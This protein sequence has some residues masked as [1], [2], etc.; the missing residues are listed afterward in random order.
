MY[1]GPFVIVE[2]KEYPIIPAGDHAS[3]ELPTSF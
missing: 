2:V 3:H 1:N